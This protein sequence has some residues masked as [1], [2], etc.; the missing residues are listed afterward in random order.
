MGSPLFYIRLELPIIPKF[1]VIFLKD[2]FI[3][4]FRKRRGEYT[5]WAGRDRGIER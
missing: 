3:Y 4:L 2:L 5:S 1:T